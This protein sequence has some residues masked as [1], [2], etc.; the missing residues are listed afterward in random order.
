STNHLDI[1]SVSWLE[2]FI[3]QSKKTFLIVSH[4][5]CFLDNITTDTLEIENGKAV[6]YSGAYSVFRQK[7]EKLREDLLK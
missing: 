1:N 6:M 5:R 2:S 3:K 7:K 4:D